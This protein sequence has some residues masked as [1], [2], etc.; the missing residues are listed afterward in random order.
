MIDIS[1]YSNQLLFVGSALLGAVAHYIKKAGKGE[2]STLVHEW[3]GAANIEAS[4]ITLFM[5]FFVMIGALVG[6]MITAETP[7]WISLYIGFVTGFA[8]DAGFNSD[9]VKQTTIQTSPP[10]PGK[11]KVVIRRTPTG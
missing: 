1:P 4:A 6:D 9:V 7:F 2:T 3:F 5:L 10:P 8:V 11:R